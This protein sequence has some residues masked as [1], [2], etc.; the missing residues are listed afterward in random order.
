[1]ATQNVIKIRSV[2]PRF[3]RAGMVF[4]RSE[5]TI[6]AS[7]LTNDQIALL[8]S[9]P[10]LVVTEAE[11]TLKDTETQA[12]VNKA[13]SLVS[14]IHELDV[15][16]QSMWTT[17]GKPQASALENLHGGSVSAKERDAAWDAY[18]AQQSDGAE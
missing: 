18:Q 14:L 15:D 2:T 7:D 13:A 6:D 8:K 4:T 11:Q 5:T 1:M 3:R 10:N 16:D 17:S 9:E 12:D